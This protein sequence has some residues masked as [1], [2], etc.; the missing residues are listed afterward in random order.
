[1]NCERHKIGFSCHKVEPFSSKD[2]FVVDP[3]HHFEI[4]LV[5][6]S[7]H[8][9]T[10]LK[11]S[12][13]PFRM[14]QLLRKAWVNKIAWWLSRDRYQELFISLLVATD[15][16]LSFHWEKG[17]ILFCFLVLKVSY[18]FSP[19]Q[20]LSYLNSRKGLVK[21]D[22]FEKSLWDSKLHLRLLFWKDFVQW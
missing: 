14:F 18:G 5:T 22:T 10:K 21:V 16:F 8:E 6:T 17:K 3:N 11:S 13:N 15:S 2:Y 1:M 20:N 7:R 9:N 19:K 12:S 4:I